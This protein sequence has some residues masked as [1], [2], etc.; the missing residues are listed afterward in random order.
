MDRQNEQRQP[1][2][3]R[4]N[5]MKKQNRFSLSKTLYAVD[6]STLLRTQVGNVQSTGKP[7]YRYEIQAAWFK[8]R[9]R[10]DTSN[11]GYLSTVSTDF[12]LHVEDEQQVKRFLSETIV[13]SRYGGRCRSRWDGSRLWSDP[14]LDRKDQEIDLKFLDSMLDRYPEIPAGYDGWWSFR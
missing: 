7:I 4:K 2:N 14:S 11:V 6:L 9:K 13:D 5:A 8:R 10:L 12:Y 1:K 3:D